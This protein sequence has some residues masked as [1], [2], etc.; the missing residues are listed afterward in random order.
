VNKLIIALAT[1]VS[2][3]C[4]ASDLAEKNQA[5]CNGPQVKAIA[6]PGDSC[7][8]VLSLESNKDMQG[9]CNGNFQESLPCA[10]VYLVS[11]D[12]AAMRIVCGPDPRNP[13]LDQTIRAE[14][15]SYSVSAVVTKKNGEDVVIND[16]REHMALA[17]GPLSLEMTKNSRK[18]NGKIT[19][20]SVELT[21]VKCR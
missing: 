17:A 6:A 16:L 8:I 19:L 15:V 4:L 3:N 11:P 21:D 13:V 14:A 10:V 9:Q 20:G 12:G 2:L 5:F 7:R 1:L 18:L